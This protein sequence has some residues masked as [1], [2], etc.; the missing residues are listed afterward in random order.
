MNKEDKPRSGRCPGAGQ[1]V[2]LI[3]C[4]LIVQTGIGLPRIDPSEHSGFETHEINV[5]AR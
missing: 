4:A 5:P 1:R 3:F 2:S